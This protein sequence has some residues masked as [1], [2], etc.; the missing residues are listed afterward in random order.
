MKEFKYVIT[1]PQGIH[2]RPAGMLVKEASKFS[3]EIKIRKGEKEG[4]AKR[5]FAVMGLAA[6][7]EDKITVTADGADE[8]EAICALE[9][10]L[11]E[12]M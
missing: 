5:I 6:K 9:S 8:A 1:D 4:D 11:K 2:A 10:F 12:N 3:S 7:K